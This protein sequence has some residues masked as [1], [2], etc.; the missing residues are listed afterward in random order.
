MTSF[1]SNPLYLQIEEYIRQQIA[2]GVYPVN[3]K[4]PSTSALASATGTSVCTVQAA[5]AKLSREGIL[6]RRTR[7]GTFV[8]GNR[9]TL[10]HA[11][12]Y[13]RRLLLRED[14]AF[15]QVLCRELQRLLGSRGVKCRIWA[16][17]RDEEECP[18]PPDSL[19]RAMERREIQA[20]IC[21]LVAG[22]DLRWL[23]DP[24]VPAS[25]LTTDMRMPN[26]VGGNFR[27]M[28]VQGLTELKNQGCRTVGVINSMQL[29]SNQPNSSELDF[30]R[31]WENA[32]NEM[33]LESR[34][35]WIRFPREFTPHFANF[36]YDQFK[37]LWSLPQRPD[38]VLVYPDEMAPGVIT[39]MLECGVTVP[40]DLKMIIHA[41]DLIP[42]VCPFPVSYLCTKVSIFANALIQQI[43]TQL[44][45]EPVA[46]IQIHTEVIRNA[47]P[48]VEI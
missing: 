48:F 34:N 26:G 45:G 23:R 8:K 36:G 3:S 13:L 6:D 25:M 18:G 28:I 12:L 15:Y 7:H 39:A 11:G 46:P 33:G 44:K 30:Y 41:N 47:S 4:L 10:T 2:E 1:K 20:L 9:A 40:R 29:R 17:E 5:L 22:P 31:F 32:T 14:S 38:G 37:R 35:E 24:K 27:E 43:D 42:Y 16:D 19:S 21:P